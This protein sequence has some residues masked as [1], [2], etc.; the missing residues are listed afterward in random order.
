[1]STPNPNHIEFA[2]LR[3]HVDA[4]NVQID[5]LAT[6]VAELVESQNA[7]L[8]SVTSIKDQVEPAVSALASHPMFRMLVGGK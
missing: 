4:L 3:A 8:A 2:K 5:G 6:I 7:I 1:M